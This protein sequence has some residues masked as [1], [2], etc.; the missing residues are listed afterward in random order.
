[1]PYRLDEQQ[2]RMSDR[3]GKQKHD[4][5]RKRVPVLLVETRFGTQRISVFETDDIRTAPRKNG[6]KAGIHRMNLLQL[7]ESL[8][9]GKSGSE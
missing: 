2:F 8:S 7:T 9:Q 3:P 5:V 4:L 6:E 1:M